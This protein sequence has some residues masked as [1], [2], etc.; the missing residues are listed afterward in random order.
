MQ[1]RGASGAP[2]FFVRVD[3]AGASPADR[4]SPAITVGPDRRDA[5]DRPDQNA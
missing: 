5:P 4:L 2:F 3:Q 1:R